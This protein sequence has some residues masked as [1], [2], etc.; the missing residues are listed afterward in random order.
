MRSGLFVAV[1][2][3]PLL[4]ACASSGSATSVGSP[5]IAGAA[6]GPTFAQG[7]TARSTSSP[8]SAPALSSAGGAARSS[9]SHPAGTFPPAVSSPLDAAFHVAAPVLLAPSG[10]GPALMQKP[11]KPAD[12]TATATTRLIGGAVQGVIRLIGHACSLHIS[13][14][15]SALLDATG[16]RLA[17][18]LQA[19]PA[20]QFIGDPRPDL[21]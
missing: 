5:T 1:A 4:A 14:G 12:V 16:H 2:V 3:F 8:V 13:G 20:D 21:P 9:P 11:C 15:P 7:P 6:S 10:P 18:P 19:R 17:V